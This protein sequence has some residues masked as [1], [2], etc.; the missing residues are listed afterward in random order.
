[1]ALDECITNAVNAKEMTKEQGDQALDLFMD[2][3]IE[4]RNQGLNDIEANS[5]AGKLTFDTLEYQAKEAKRRRL[6][7]LAVWAQ[8]KYDLENYRDAAGNKNIAKAAVAKIEGDEFSTYSSLVERS[9]ELE[10][11]MTS[12]L[13]NF[14]SAHKRN[15]LGAV[16]NRAKMENVVKE[17]HKQNTG[18]V[19]AREMADAITKVFEYARTK[20]NEAGGSIPKMERY[21]LPQNHDDV[22]IRKAGK[23]QWTSFVS[24]RLDRNAMLD[25]QTGLPMS[26]FRL[27][28]AL[29]DVW[30]TLA[31][32]GRNKIQPGK[33]MQG[34]SV[35]ASRADHRFL[36]FKD[37]ESWLEYNKRFGRATAFDSIVGHIHSMANDIAQMQILGPNPNTMIRYIQDMIEKDKIGKSEFEIVKMDFRKKLLS[38]MFLVHNGTLNQMN[39]FTNTFAG[40]RN[41]I[42]A[43]VLGSASILAVTDL[44]YQRIARSSSGLPQTGIIKDLL[45][46]I[47]PINNK[48]RKLAVRLG[49]I[50]EAW[51][52]MA[53]AQLRFMG[54]VTGPELT[55]R[56]SDFTMRASLLTPWTQVGRWAFGMEMLGFLADNAGKTFDE[57]PVQLKTTLSKYG[58][59]QD[60]WNII[61]TTPL[62]EFEGATFLRGQ[63]IEAR[64]DINP[65]LAFELGTRVMEMVGTETN[66]AVPSSSLK[67]RTFLVGDTNPN[68][69]GGQLA[70]SFAMYKNF[71]VTLLNTHIMR[72]L[73]Q[74]SARKK[75]TYAADLILSATLFGGLAY[76]LKEITKGRDPRDMT[77]SSFWLQA[78]LTGGGFGIIGDILGSSANPYQRSFTQAIAGPVTAVAE[79]FIGMPGKN[80]FKLA[81][82]KDTSVTTDLIKLAHRYTPGT[83]IWYGRLALERLVFDR[84]LQWA[85][86][87]QYK[88]LNRIE[89]KSYRNYGQKYWWGRGQDAPYRA[90]DLSAA[91]GN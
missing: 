2:N 65:T 69:L 9:R 8:V 67:G 35:G 5:R 90:P 82:G 11:R 4:F 33:V 29:D 62:Y 10:N 32:N 3:V 60:R 64:T 56:I 27:L 77:D 59:E 63:D 1:M 6:K 72:S 54:D 73:A 14:L 25:M 34:K 78:V 81:E 75:I 12:L 38:D 86:P 26:D 18:D 71:G 52:S 30:E 91:L 24:Q 57:L 48:D 22:L 58:I 31:T 21:A 19:S 20:F 15:L 50:S 42:N 40:L 45:K 85:D 23:D 17:L 36:I 84:A 16:R 47:N 89:R 53:S 68:S 83:S 80:I 74:N 88:K 70:R 51:T 79:D 41:L 61:R 43:A 66:F 13:D 39:M 46:L 28:T 7:Q 49:L 76:Q 87:D 37:A 44:N 55:R